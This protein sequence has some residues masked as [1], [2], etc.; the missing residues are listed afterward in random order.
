MPQRRRTSPCRRKTSRPAP[1]MLSDPRAGFQVHLRKK[2][3]NAYM[4][5]LYDGR[6]SAAAVQT[7]DSHGRLVAV[8]LPLDDSS[9][10][11]KFNGFLVLATFPHE[12]IEPDAALANPEVRGCEPHLRVSRFPPALGRMLC[13][14]AKYLALPVFSCR[15]EVACKR[16]YLAQ[17]RDNHRQDR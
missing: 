7:G 15:M 11:Q 3:V 1:Y 16:S 8:S 12:G 13:R 2:Y 9:V 10:I 17:V 6:S 5:R 14:P 4:V